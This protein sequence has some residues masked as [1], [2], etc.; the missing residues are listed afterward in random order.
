MLRAADSFIST[1]VTLICLWSMA[2]ITLT[3]L[4]LTVGLLPMV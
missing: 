1:D 3:A 2:G 4:M